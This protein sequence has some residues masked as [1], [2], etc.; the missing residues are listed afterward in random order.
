MKTP[1]VNSDAVYKRSE[2]L[3]LLNSNNFYT[4]TAIAIVL[5]IASAF[6]LVEN[7]RKLKTVVDVLSYK[8]SISHPD[9]QK[10]SFQAFQQERYDLSASLKNHVLV[11]PSSF[12]SATQYLFDDEL[13]DKSHRIKKGIKR[14]AFSYDITSNKF[15]NDL[16]SADIGLARDASHKD[17]HILHPLSI[18]EEKNAMLENN[19]SKYS[20]A[21]DLKQK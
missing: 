2:F 4:V 3:D 20:L 11:K 15:W 17:S 5:G 14:V 9:N 7:P 8:V 19:D 1:N 6:G 12:N 18:Q 13:A 21:T 16:S 10:M